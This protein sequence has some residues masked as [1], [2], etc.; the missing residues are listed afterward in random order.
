MP[1]MAAGRPSGRA[2]GTG[3]TRPDPALTASVASTH[4]AGRTFVLPARTCTPADSAM[5]R[6]QSPDLV[7]A[8]A[9][10]YKQT[11]ESQGLKY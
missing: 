8:T 1:S 11:K 7:R 10:V 4:T 5:R 6:V 3:G 9:M 2:V